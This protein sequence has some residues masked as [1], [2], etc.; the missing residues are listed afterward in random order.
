ML[1]DRVRS[2]LKDNVPYTNW[3]DDTE[4]RWF[5][6]NDIKTWG[7]VI[8]NIRVTRLNGFEICSEDWEIPPDRQTYPRAPHDSIV[9][10]VITS[11]GFWVQKPGYDYQALFEKPLTV[12]CDR[13]EA[14][15]KEYR[16]GLAEEKS[17]KMTK[18]ISYTYD[19]FRNDNVV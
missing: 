19:V 15:I 10:Q 14:E 9:V 6:D 7:A 1:L 18:L 12:F 16:D 5:F 13:L 4:T 8:H 3:F 2:I 11:A 17:R